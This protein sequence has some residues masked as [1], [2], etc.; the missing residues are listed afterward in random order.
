MEKETPELVAYR[1]HIRLTLAGLGLPP[2]LL[3]G[4][5]RGPH[6]EALDL[7]PIGPDAFGRE[8]RLASATATAWEKMRTSAAGDGV[9][10]LVISAF[11]SF[12]RQ[13]DI[14]ARKL[15]A[16]QTIGEIL[17]VSALP[18]YSEHHTGRAIDLGTPGCP[19]LTTGFAD[20]PAFAWLQ[21]HAGRFGFTLSYPRDN[22]HGVTFEPWHWC[23][24]DMPT[25][26]AIHPF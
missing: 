24:H 11:R 19:H 13:R 21:L 17:R 16:G 8:Q 10:L 23:R 3:D 25:G 9:C 7:V 4:R 1:E 26:P 20:T 2:A 15:E 22:P 14:I 5:T 18:G 12:D 6:L